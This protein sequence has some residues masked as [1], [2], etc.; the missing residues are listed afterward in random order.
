MCQKDNVIMASTCHIL[1]RFAHS[2]IFLMIFTEKN[3]PRKTCQT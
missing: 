1:S 3:K 2:V